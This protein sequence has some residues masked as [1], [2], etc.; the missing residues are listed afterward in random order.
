MEATTV[1]ALLQINPVSYCRL[2]L[3]SSSVEPLYPN[4]PK[5]DLIDLIA[6]SVQ[7]LI[8]EEDLPCAVCQN[9]RLKLE[10]FERF[11]D[12]CQKLDDFVRTRRRE[13]ALLQETVVVQ[14]VGDSASMV[15]SEEIAIKADPEA[16]LGEEDSLPYV[17]TEDS[18]HRCKFCSEAF[19]SLSV[20]L[21]HFRMRHPDESKMYKCPHCAQ[22]YSIEIS[23]STSPAYKCDECDAGFG[24]RVGLTRHKDRYHDKSSPN[25]STERFKCDHCSS[26]FA[27]S[28]QRSKHQMQTHMSISGGTKISAQVDGIHVCEKCAV[29]FSPYQALLVH[30]Q[31]HHWNDPPQETFSCSVCSKP[32]D[33]RRLLQYHILVAHLGQIPYACNHCGE[34][35]RTKS[36]LKQHKAMFHERAT[37]DVSRCEFC[38]QTF[39]EEPK[40]QIS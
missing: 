6:K 33:K 11:R 28:K 30:I 27:D 5:Q 14:Q 22:T 10:D 20:L 3:S 36:H 35:F 16:L 12:Q 32:F 29:T 23:G 31:E 39:E 26:V 38:G 18:W 25:Y 24:H 9:C 15:V 21:E 8:I 17:L 40:D 2:C 37:G 34:W 19:Q 7:V 4:S 1:S 13:L